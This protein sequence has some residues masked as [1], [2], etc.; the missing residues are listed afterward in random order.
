M[1]LQL[2]QSLWQ[3][4][5]RVAHSIPFLITLLLA[6]T[7]LLL[8]KPNRGGK[9][10]LPPSPPKL[11]IIGNLHQ[12]GSLPHRSLQALSNKHGPLMFLHL[13]CA[14]TLVVSS[15][16]MV[17]EMIKSHDI[18]FSNRVRT[19][20]VDILF[21][22]STDMAFAPYGE[23]WRK[24]KKICIQ[25]LLSLDRVQS[26]Q[27]LREEEV[28][29]LV[30]KIR[31]SCQEGKPVNLSE[32]LVNVTNNIIFRTVIGQRNEEEDGK[33]RYGE[34]WMRVMVELASFSFRDYF[35]SLGWLDVLTGVT[36]RLKRT[37]KEIDAFFEL[38]IKEHKN[39]MLTTDGGHSNQKNFLGILLK[40]QEDS[41]LD[42]DLNH[43]TA[44][45][46][47]YR[48]RPR[49]RVGPEDRY[50]LKLSFWSKIR[51]M[52]VGA[53][54]TSIATMEWAMSVLIKNPIIMKKAQEEVREVVGGK[55]KV[56]VN[57]VNQMCYLKCIVKETLRLHHPLPFLVPRETSAT[58]KLGGYDIPCKTRV[59]VN[60]WAIQRDPK[61]WDNAEE[62]LPE[63]F[64]SKS[65]P[66][67]FLGNDF[68]YTPFGCGRRVCPGMSFGLATVEYV[69]ANLLYWFDWELPGGAKGEDLDMSEVFGLSI[70]KKVPLH[71]V[72]T[73]YYP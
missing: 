34:L 31:C 51:D 69:L 61:F 12:L 60:S 33:N 59:Y 50:R 37:F 21:N 54:N 55:L 44:S 20:A 46:Q 47:S 41:M 4:S 11:P 36:S 35:P 27:F 2:L 7:L 38:V 40:L 70:H 65:N 28:D 22:G 26:F 14:P 67:E 72:A 73:A 23:Y 30:K 53:T 19:T 32:L 71:L 66:I 64:N 5:Y 16:E 18:V 1:D 15:P 43:V 3:E 13:G 25:E 48:P 62:F 57:D 58:A 42:F 6:L 8:L 10:N 49:P 39:K 17:S 63:R 56:D 68:Q 45:K 29:I 24:V 52:F 9:F